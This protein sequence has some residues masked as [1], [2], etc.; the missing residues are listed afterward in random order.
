M[1]TPSGGLL[2]KLAAADRK[3]GEKA[4]TPAVHSI[5]DAVDTVKPAKDHTDDVADAV[6][7]T[8]TSRP[9]ATAAAAPHHHEGDTAVSVNRSQFELITETLPGV[10]KTDPITNHDLGL[11]PMI[12]GLARGLDHVAAYIREHTERVDQ[13]NWTTEDKIIVQALDAIA[14]VQNTAG[15]VAEKALMILESSPRWQE[16]QAKMASPK[17]ASADVATGRMAGY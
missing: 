14:D 7:H 3:I 17:G 2:P 4:F 8:P 15:P 13:A 10:A 5:L 16:L 12:Q 11:K 6:V 1:G 9:K